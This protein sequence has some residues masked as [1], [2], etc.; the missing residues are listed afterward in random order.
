MT[1]LE[2]GEKYGVTKERARQLEEQIKARL[3]TYV[4]EHYPDFN[5]L[6]GL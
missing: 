3:K 5:L 2:I 4:A 1:L 6:T